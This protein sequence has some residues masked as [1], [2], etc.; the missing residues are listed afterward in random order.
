MVNKRTIAPPSTPEVPST[1][2][3][4]AVHVPAPAAPLTWVG[5]PIEDADRP[6][7]I[8]ED[9]TGLGLAA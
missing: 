8:L 4:E 3:L 7:S 2:A 9:E 5:R 1:D 6:Y